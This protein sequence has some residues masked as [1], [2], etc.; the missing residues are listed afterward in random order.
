MFTIDCKVV[1]NIK[2]QLQN[3]ITYTS[4]MLEHTVD[5]LKITLYFHVL[6]SAQRCHHNGKFELNIL[7][8]I[9]HPYN[10]PLPHN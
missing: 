1:Y 8:V 9:G 6:Y 5:Y 2:V 3:T 4:C 7:Y 10:N